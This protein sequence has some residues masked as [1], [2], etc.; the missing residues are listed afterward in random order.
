MSVTHNRNSVPLLNISESLNDNDNS[1]VLN[2]LN[3]PDND[4]FRQVDSRN[5]THC[6]TSE[7]CNV[8][9]SATDC[10]IFHVNIRSIPAHFDEFETM[11][12]LL[13]SPQFIG[14]SET[15]LKDHNI[16]HYS[17]DHY[18]HFHKMRPSR[19]GGGVSILAR[20]NMDYTEV[21][22]LGD[23]FKDSAEA[24]F[25][26]TEDKLPSFNRKVLVGEIY[27]PPSLPTQ[28]FIDDFVKLLEKLKS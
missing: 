16:S 17:L 25:I 8:P 27:R 13:K 18:Q 28:P 10:C 9:L 4:L 15:W 1:R 5:L 22:E 14:V 3:A 21:S 12:D 24:I 19:A 11:V 23:L 7:I 20:N 26:E 2:D 6:T